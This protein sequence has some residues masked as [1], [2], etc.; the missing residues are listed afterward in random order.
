[1]LVRIP[2]AWTGVVGKNGSNVS[3]IKTATVI[4]LS[5]LCLN[6]EKFLIFICFNIPLNEFSI[7]IEIPILLMLFP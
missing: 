4:I 3:M 7:Y 6:F 2:A 1:M 5:R